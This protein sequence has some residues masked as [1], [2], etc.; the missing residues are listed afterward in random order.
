M[1]VTDDTL[2]THVRDVGKADNP[3]IYTHKMVSTFLI[4]FSMLRQRRN[5]QQD[6]YSRMIRLPQINT[7]AYL[8]RHAYELIT[9]RQILIK[10]LLTVSRPI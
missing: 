10:S 9:I 4:L 2:A 5:L 7:H 6:S 1:I 8:V 3:H